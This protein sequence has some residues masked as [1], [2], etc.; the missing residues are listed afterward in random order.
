MNPVKTY[1]KYEDRIVTLYPEDVSGRVHGD[2]PADGVEV[3]L[4]RREKA[5]IPQIKDLRN[6]IPGLTLAQAK[7]IADYYA[8]QDVVP[9]E[10]IITRIESTEDAAL[11]E[12]REKLVG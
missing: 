5:K 6:L 1:S 3:S 10:D 11:R 2:W 9:F 12:L 8:G 7:V 4:G